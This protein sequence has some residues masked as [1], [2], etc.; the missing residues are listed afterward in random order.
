MKKFLLIFSAVVLIGASLYL[1]FWLTMADA[2]NRQVQR[3]Y[4]PAAGTMFALS[5]EQPRVK[6]FPG[7]PVLQYS[8]DVHVSDLIFHV[9]LAE[10]RGFY[11]PGQIVEVSFPKGIIPVKPADPHKFVTLQKL[12]F[13]LVIPEEWPAYAAEEDLWKWQQNGNYL[14]IRDLHLQ[15][16]DIKIEGV[17]LLSLDDN[18]QPDIQFDLVI[19]TPDALIDR[20]WKTGGISDVQKGIASAVINSIPANK[21]DKANGTIRLRVIARN[22]MLWVGEM[23]VAPLPEIQWPR[24]R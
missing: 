24:S 11:L 21:Q 15:T 7:K 2:V 8:G 13:G 9:P 4:S 14:D 18:L 19:Y 6:G 22:Q 1:G 5:G 10:I 16:Q 17:G 3:A 20:L 23:P 12:S